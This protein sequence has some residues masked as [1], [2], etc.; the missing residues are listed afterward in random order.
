MLLLM[1]AGNAQTSRYGK[2][3]KEKYPGIKYLSFFHEYDSED[4]YLDSIRA[5]Y[6]VCMSIPRGFS[7]ELSDRWVNYTAAKDHGASYSIS[8]FNA[9]INGNG[10]PGVIV[11]RTLESQELSYIP[12]K[13]DVFNASPFDF[14]PKGHVIPPEFHIDDFLTHMPRKVCD[15]FGADELLVL[16]VPLGRMEFREWIFR[17]DGNTPHKLQ[18]CWEEYYPRA[19]RYYFVKN[20]KPAFDIVILT[21][22]KWAE[23]PGRIIRVLKK[24][25]HY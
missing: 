9:I 25:I 14:V 2:Y 1:V 7:L 24:L 22:E 15:V 21:T 8:L 5:Q 23:H 13:F 19:F 11:L 20:G 16:P 17:K 3:V 12:L 18:E 6:G 4:E 10:F